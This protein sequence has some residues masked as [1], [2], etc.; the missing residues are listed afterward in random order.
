M[1]RLPPFEYY[2]PK[3]AAQAAKMLAE[4]GPEALLVAGGT[5]VYPKMKRYQFQPKA[6]ISLKQI[7]RLSG[8]L[9]SNSK[10]FVL[11]SGTTLTEVASHSSLSKA[12]PGLAKAA[13]V[14]STPILRNMGTIGGNL[15]LDTRC[16]YYDQTHHWR[17]SISWCMKAPGAKGVLFKPSATRDESIPCRVAPG[18]DRCWAVSST[19]TAPVM[20][21]LGAQVVLVS[22]KGERVI[23]AKQLYCDDGIRYVT[24]RPDEILTEIHLPPADGI[25]TT[26]LKL[27]RRG[28]FDFPVLGVAV[29]LK[30]AED[31]TITDCKIVLGGI[32]SYPVEFEQAEKMLIGQKPT[33]ELIEHVAQTVFG[34]ARPMDNTDYQI[35][36]R[37]RMAPVYVKRALLELTS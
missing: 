9:G 3:S 34:P 37:K 36:Y 12:Y 10:G 2:A 8:I 22:A 18:G 25:K 24:K 16:N 11:K 1:L 29:A 17:K 35:Y 31:K 27:R 26:Y 13:G 21:A 30:Q 28:S 7:K 19:D 5:D 15:C 14:V 20:V 23:P 4:F 6:L 33:L 32:A